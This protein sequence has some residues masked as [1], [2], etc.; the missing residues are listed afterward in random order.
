MRS[1]TEVGVIVAA[2]FGGVVAATPADQAPPP[3]ARSS[4]A[5][6][7]QQGRLGVPLVILPEAAGQR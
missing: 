4:G 1:G 3:G 6:E 7:T 5:V 2:L